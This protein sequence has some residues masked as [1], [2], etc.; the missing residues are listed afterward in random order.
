M[1][2]STFCRASLCCLFVF[3]ALNSARSQLLSVDINGQSS[4]ASQS[5]APGFVAWNMGSQTGAGIQSVSQ[6]FTNYTYTYDPTTGLPTATNVNLIIPCT[7]AMTYPTTAS[8]QNYLNA[9]NANKTGY[10]T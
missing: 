1:N 2:H 4:Q 7:V 9:K 6:S 10:T 5:T 8:A 3:L